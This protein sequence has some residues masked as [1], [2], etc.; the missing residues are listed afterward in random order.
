M[1]WLHP[2]SLSL[3]SLA[4]T[5]SFASNK[6]VQ[7][8][9]E[10]IPSDPSTSVRFV[11]EQEK[12][13]YLDKSDPLFV[14]KRLFVPTI[15]RPHLLKIAHDD[16]LYGGHLGLKKT[17]RKLQDFWWPGMHAA[18]T[19]FVR[20][21]DICQKTKN[22]RIPTPGLLHHMPLS[23]IFERLHLDLVGP[24]PRSN[25]DNV[26]IITAIDAFSRFAFAKAVPDSKTDQII[27]FLVEDIVAKHGLPL[28][29]TT[30]RG[31]Q[32]ESHAWEEFI[33]KHEI[34]H[35]MTTPYHPSANGMDERFNASIQKLIRTYINTDQT[36][37]DERLPWC[38]FNY[39]TTIHEST[40]H[41]PFSIMYGYKPRSP[42][43]VCQESEDPP[44]I[45][46]VR[47]AIR[48]ACLQNIEKAHQVQKLYYDRRHS[49][50]VIKIGDEVLHRLHTVKSPR[51]TKL[52][53]KWVG[54]F[55][56]CDIVGPEH[57][58]KAIVIADLTT[59]SK[60]TVAVQHVK[61]YDK[62][63]HS[64][65]AEHA[66][67]TEFNE[68]PEFI[69]TTIDDA[70][71][72]C[73]PPTMLAHP[74]LRLRGEMGR[75]LREHFEQ[76]PPTPL[77][78][79]VLNAPPA[80]ERATQSSSIPDEPREV[81]ANNQPQVEPTSPPTI[82]LQPRPPSPHD[83]PISDTATPLEMVTQP[84]SIS[85]EIRDVVASGHPSMEPA[86]TPPVQIQSKIPQITSQYS[87]RPREKVDYKHLQRP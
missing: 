51:S 59:L 46:E 6:E 10:K 65:E 42:L 36:D 18:I 27:K 82:P 41:S 86:R 5:E 2:I 22:P 77:D 1:F 67:I 48:T 66:E 81:V 37:W 9:I 32:F 75:R 39:N 21:C 11:L 14:K 61:P 33:T 64:L 45:Q 34:R 50:C 60:K 56:V 30:D 15:S 16:I 49:K 85:S 23:R 73:L 25:S 62:A 28:Q 80:S 74:D 12:L 68:R 72:V 20:S 47:S 13:Y 8:I 43:Q 44:N 71:P 19:Q 83:Y 7:D 24:K 69:P 26:Y 17:S 29:I 54:P 40:K 84:S 3:S 79:Q 78:P 55:L 4:L 53:H 63:D 52:A 70:V 35:Q 87:L 57:N 76:R 38:I 31:A 58:P